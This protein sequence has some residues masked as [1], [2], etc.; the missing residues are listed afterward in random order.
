M[1]SRPSRDKG[2]LGI[3][4]AVL[5]VVSAIS[6]PAA[7]APEHVECGQVITRSTT[8]AN[9]LRC[10]GDAI[11][12]GAPN[13]TIDLAGHSVGANTISILNAGFDNVSIKNGEVIVDTLGIALRGADGNVIRDITLRGLQHGIILTG[14]DRNRII[15]NRLESVWISA[16]DGSDGNVITRNTVLGYEAFIAV[17]GSSNRVIDNLISTGNG[18]TAI[19]LGGARDTLVGRNDITVDG[20]GG[21]QLGG[22]DANHVI[23]NTVQGQSPFVDGLTLIDSDENLLSGNLFL[24]TTTAVDVTS[25]NGNALER[26]Q[27][28]NGLEDGF[29]VQARATSTTLRRNVA[30]GW[31]DDGIDIEAPGTELG[32]NTANHNGDLGIEAVS[33]VV[34][35][36]ANRAAGNGNALQCVNVFCR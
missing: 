2:R 29:H 20:G 31:A 22:S 18:E 7:A 24:D 36:G 23:G 5:G 17:G 21:V 4:L 15:S 28:V 11:H 3:A 8:L 35:L 16:F 33:G 14:S 1:R 9:D 10:T 12:V 32:H 19:I 6:A 13:I 34:D 26:N 25:G 27:A 30:R